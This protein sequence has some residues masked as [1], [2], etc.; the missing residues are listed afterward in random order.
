MTTTPEYLYSTDDEQYVYTSLTD[1]L[2]SMYYSKDYEN[3]EV[4]VVFEAEATPL[5]ISAMCN[6]LAIDTIYNYSNYVYSIIGEKYDPRKPQ[7]TESR[8]ELKA[9]IEQ[10]VYNHTSASLRKELSDT[11]ERITLTRA[12]VRKY[13]NA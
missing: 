2:K 4:F 11:S 1:C 13:L 12:E 9:A 7:S 5:D 3:A 6:S 8:D 10:W